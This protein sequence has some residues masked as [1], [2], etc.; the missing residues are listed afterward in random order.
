MKKFLKILCVVSMV[1]AILCTPFSNSSLTLEAQAQTQKAHTNITVGQTLN[2][3]YT[4]TYHEF[5]APTTGIYKFVLA[6][7]TGG[8]YVTNK[9]KY[10]PGKRGGLLQATYL[11]Q[12]GDIIKIITGDIGPE[13]RDSSG[14]GADGGPGETSYIYKRINGVNEL[15]LH[16]SGGN[17][18]KNNSQDGGDNFYVNSEDLIDSSSVNNGADDGRGYCNITLMEESFIINNQPVDTSVIATQD[19]TMK[20]YSEL[21]TKTGYYEWFFFNDTEDFNDWQKIGAVSAVEN[22]GYPVSVSASKDGKS[23][24]IEMKENT[25]TGTVMSYLTLK[26]SKLDDH[27]LRIKCVVYNTVSASGK[28]N[29]ESDEIAL[30]VK[31]NGYNKII[32]SY[33]KTAPAGSEIDIE[34]VLVALMYETGEPEFATGWSNLCFVITKDVTMSTM[35]NKDGTTSD[36]VETITQESKTYP[37]K[38]GS[39]T[40]TVRLKDTNP[41]PQLDE[42]GKPIMDSEGKPVLDDCTKETTFTTTGTD[43]IFPDFEDIVFSEYEVTNTETNPVE[44]TVTLK[45]TDNFTIDLLYAFLPSDTAVQESDFSDKTT[46]NLS[47]SKNTLYK[48]YVKDI[49]GNITEKEVTIV[50]TDNEPPVIISKS[51]VFPEEWVS[52]NIIEVEATDNYKPELMKYKFEL[53]GNSDVKT[54]WQ[55]KN[56]LVIV[57]NGTYHIAVKDYV[58]NITETTLRVV[59]V[60]TKAPDIKEISIK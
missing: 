2:Y 60:D 36:I 39:N 3:G 12:K 38:Y 19:A 16:A 26:K 20:C 43:K 41:Q 15:L 28:E 4:N 57:G 40:V 25:D 18:V 52:K 50:V 54:D 22:S 55:D 53:E 49:A 48:A 10:Y 35:K 24:E 11:L 34:D 8:M 29:L 17:C 7:A 23:F 27:E 42:N 6:G 47:L 5:V 9:D 31:R 51:L 32:A 13:A 1:C 45:A 30:N 14:P 37:V 33:Y 21:G 56:S 44:I 46:Y 58:G 59:N